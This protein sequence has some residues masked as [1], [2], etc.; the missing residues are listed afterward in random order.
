MELLKV[1]VRQMLLLKFSIPKIIGAVLQR[2]P[3]RRK[4]VLVEDKI[5]VGLAVQEVDFQTKTK[6][7]LPKTLLQKTESKVRTE[8][9]LKWEFQNEKTFWMNLTSLSN[10]LNSDRIK[11]SKMPFLKMNLNPMFKLLRKSKN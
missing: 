1:W 5:V 11:A 9:Q 3:N 7:H 4:V 8:I 6:L 10:N 2:M